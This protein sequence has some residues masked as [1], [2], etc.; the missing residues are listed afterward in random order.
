MKILVLAPQARYDAYSADNP[1]R[2][3]CE[4]I[5]LDRDSS[6][7]E[8]LAAAGDADAI[9]TTPVTFIR[10][11]LISR[12]PNLK[13]IHSEGVGF[14]RIDLDA[15]AKR[16][17]YVCNNAGCNASAV[18][19]MAVMLMSM[20]LHRTLWGDRM[21]RQGRQNVAVHELEVHI[22]SD[23]SV[24]TVGLV[25]FGHIAQATARLLRAY[26]STVYYCARHQASPETE[27]A[28]GVSR[29]PLEELTARCDIVSLHLPANDDTC[30]IVN[31]AFLARMKPT[32][33]LVNTGRG[34]LIDD[35]A[36]C[37][38]IRRRSIA[39]AG[40]DCYD[41]E[42]VTAEHPLV[43]LAAEYPDALVL[44]PHQGGISTS[45]F[46]RA[47]A[48]LFHDLQ[49]LMEGKRPEHICNGL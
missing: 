31:A 34:A 48:M 23:L 11:S 49:L 5:F 30:H 2:K 12:M 36:L 9:F 44:S 40:L 29:L 16:G 3:Q 26:G 22:P 38:A 4:L 10:E 28:L 25:G 46:H 17:I 6:E 45:A 43:R 41:P 8:M 35:E 15:A 14:D 18:A 13:M 24:S 39:G 20:L 47:H 32:A 19:E 42:P 21:V 37:D 27:A 1:V 7:A 33:F